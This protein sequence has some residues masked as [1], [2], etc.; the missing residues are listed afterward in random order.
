MRYQVRVR[1][2]RRYPRQVI[3]LWGSPSLQPHA[4]LR[5]VPIAVDS[6]RRLL[7]ETRRCFLL[8]LSLS[9]LGVLLRTFHSLEVLA[10]EL[11]QSDQSRDAADEWQS[12][13]SDH[14]PS[15]QGVVPVVVR[16][17]RLVS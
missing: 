12:A 9:Q 6:E 16:T 17:I 15:L 5:I 13:L 11:P 2:T 14:L 1:V 7:E 10:F 4:T 8:S 3:Y